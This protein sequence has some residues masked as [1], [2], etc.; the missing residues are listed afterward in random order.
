[1]GDRIYM[2]CHFVPSVCEFITIVSCLIYAQINSI[3]VNFC[4]NFATLTNKTQFSGITLFTFIIISVK[5]Q[6]KLLN[7]LSPPTPHPSCDIIPNLFSV[8]AASPWLLSPVNSSKNQLCCSI[9]TNDLRLT[10]LRVRLK[11]EC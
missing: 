5:Y 3:C 1:M 8:C 7:K 4:Q 9:K 6:L 11:P 2:P 10:A